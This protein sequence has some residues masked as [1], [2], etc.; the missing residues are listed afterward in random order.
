MKADSRLIAQGAQ[1]PGQQ[2]HGGGA[3]D[4]VQGMPEQQQTAVDMQRFYHHELAANSGLIPSN[5]E[6]MRK[7]TGTYLWNSHCKI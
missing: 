2:S 3:T 1:R 7:L 4:S 5:S 6:T